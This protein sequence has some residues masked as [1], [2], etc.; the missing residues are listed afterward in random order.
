M[1]SKM[2]KYLLDKMFE[3]LLNIMLKGGDR[4]EIL[5]WLLVDEGWRN[6]G[7]T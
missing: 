3:Y 5:K 7:S 2:P 4:H 1:L 6:I